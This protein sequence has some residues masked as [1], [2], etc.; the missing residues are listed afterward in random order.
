LFRA[1]YF[2]DNFFT[3]LSVNDSINSSLSHIESIKHELEATIKKLD[4]IYK[5]SVKSS[6]SKK[7]RIETIVAFTE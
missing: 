6:D 4:E 5:N 3:D 1:N 2:F 7:K